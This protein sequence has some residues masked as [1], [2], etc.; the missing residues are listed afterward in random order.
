MTTYSVT[1]C[2]LGPRTPST[3]GLQTLLN[4]PSIQNGGRVV[5]IVPDPREPSKLLIVTAKESP[6]RDPFQDL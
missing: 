2:F 5:S 6:D 4:H 1:S 3:D